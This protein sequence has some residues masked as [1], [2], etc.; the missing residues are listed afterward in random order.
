MHHLRRLCLTVAVAAASC[1]V[2]A[3]AQALPGR[4]RVKLQ[5]EVAQ[6]VDALPGARLQSLSKD[7]GMTGVAPLDATLQQV[8]AVKMRRV[9]PCSKERE[10]EHQK[11]GLDQWYEITFDESV[12]PLEAKRL[13]QSTAGVEKAST[14]R[15]MVLHETGRPRIVDPKAVAPKASTAMPF[16]DPKL[17]QQWHYYNDGSMAGAVAG[18]DINL[19]KAWD[20]CTGSK[21][22]VV[23]IIDGG[24]DYT[25]EDLADAMWINEAE[26]NGT[27]GVDDDG[28]GYIDDIYGYNFCTNSGTIYPHYHGTH[29]AGTI[30]AVNNNGKGVCG[31]AGG[32]GVNPGVRLM[33]CQVFDSRSGTDE[34]D[35]AAALVYAADKGAT[36]ASCSW[37][38]GT[39][40]Y[41]EED[42]LE[43]VRYFTRSA[44]SN[45]M[46]GGLCIFS[47]GNDG[48][49]GK[50]YPGAMDEVVAVASMTYDLLP[51]SYSNYGDW[52]D[53]TAPG[54]NTDYDEAQAVLS[55]YPGNQYAFL[56]GTS[57]ATPHVS[58][59]AALVLS[60]YG[61]STLINES[62]RQQ[63][64]TSVND[65]Y[66]R[67]PSYEGKF[68]S[69]YIDAYKALQWSDG[70]APAA[71]SDLEVLPA[72]DYA[73][74]TWTIP[75]SSDNQVYSHIIYYNTQPFTEETL[76]DCNSVV[77]DTKFLSSGDTYTYEVTDLSPLTTYY[78]AIRAVDRWSNASAL[79]PLVSATTNAGPKMS[80]NRTSM[81][82]STSDGSKWNT[83]RFVISNLDEGLLKWS[84]KTRTTSSSILAYSTAQGLMTTPY[85]G[86]LGLQPKAI[87]S[88]PVE[89]IEDFTQEDYPKSLTYEQSLYAFLGDTDSSKPNSMAQLFTISSDDFPEGFNLTHVY[90]EGYYGKT[91]VIE[92]YRNAGT[93]SSSTLLETY[94]TT[95]TAAYYYDHQLPETLFFEP[96]E[97]FY[98][99]V[100][101]TEWDSRSYPLGMALGDGS[102]TAAQTYISNDLGQTWTLLSQALVGSNYEEYAS[103]ATWAITVK[104]KFPDWSQILSIDPAEGQLRGG[105][106][107]TQTVAVTAN[108]TK[109]PN[110][111][112]RTKILFDT[113]ETEENT[114]AVNAAI[115]VEG[116][117]PD[118]TYN[119]II[120][121]GNVL[122]G[123]S[124]TISIELVNKGYGAFAGGKT[125]A[126]LYGDNIQSTSEHFHGPE[127]LQS[128]IPSRSTVTVDLTYAPT[129]A[130]SHNGQIKLIDKDGYTVTLNV[131]G[132]ATDPAKLV[133]NPSTVNV[134]ELNATTMEGHDVTFEIENQGNYPLQYVMT[135]FSDEE[136]DEVATSS[137]HRFGYNWIS[138]LYGSDAVTYEGA[139][140]L[141]D[142][143]D[144]STE[145]GD[146]TY[147]SS[148]VEIGF[149]FPFYGKNYTQCHITSWGS[150]TFD[151]YTG[152]LMYFPVGE[153]TTSYLSGLGVISAYGFECQMAPTS[154]VLYARQDGKFVVSYKDVLVSVYGNEYTP[155]SFHIAL[156]PSGD[157]DV[158]FDDYDPSTVFEKGHNLWV[159]IVDPDMADPLT[160][161][162][163]GH[164]VDAYWYDDT[165]E[166][167]NRWRYISTGSQFHFAA[168]KPDMIRAISPS[169]GIVPP[170]ES[171]T[172]TATVGATD[173]MY[174]GDTYTYLVIQSND[175]V[176]PT[177]LVTFEGTVTGDLQ[178]MLT[179]DQEVDFGQ[180]FRTST[181]QKALT[182]K[183]SGRSAMTLQSAAIAAGRFSHDFTEAVT[184]EPGQSKDIVLT[185]P[186]TV[187]GAVTDQLS[188][189][190]SAGNATVSLKGEV[191]G[192][193]EAGLS[194]ESL[195]VT[196]PS[197]S[198]EVYP[199]TV[200]NRGNETLSYSIVPGNHLSFTPDY[201]E[202][203]ETSYSY[204]SSIDDASALRDWV[205]IETTGL[206][207]QM[208]YTHFLLHDIVPVE[209]PFEFPYYGGKYS[210][211]YIV[212]SGF[213]TFNQYDDTAGEF[214]EPPEEFPTG[215]LYTNLLAPYWGN[216]TMDVTSTSGIFYYVTDD[217]AVV[218]F[219]EYGNSMNI[220]IDFQVIL[221][222]DGTFT[223]NYK[224][225]YDNATLFGTFGLAGIIGPTGQ[226]GI[227]LPD[228]MI[229]L[230]SSVNFNPVVTSSLA[231][232]ES[233]VADITVLGDD[234]AG[235]YSTAIKVNTN[236]PTTPE[237]PIPVALTIT[238]EPRAVF[239][240]DITVEQVAEY[241]SSDTSDDLIGYYGAMWY[242]PLQVA[243]EGTKAFTVKR[244]TMTCPQYEG[245]NMFSLYYYGTYID[246]W[247]EQE[248]T[249]WSVYT[250]GSIE[251]G[252]SPLRLA[253]PLTFNDYS[254]VAWATPGTYDIALTFSLSGIDG[255]TEKTVN[256]KIIIT[257][258]PTIAVD[259][260]EIRVKATTDTYVGTTPFTISN[261]QG[262]YKLS[263]AVVVDPT[264]EGQA[265]EAATAIQSSKQD[266]TLTDIA[267]EMIPA[268]LERRLAPKDVIDYGDDDLIY[269]VPTEGSLEYRRAIY[270]PALSTST[271]MWNYGTTTTYGT[272]KSATRYVGPEGGF[273]ISHIYSSIHPYNLDN[274]DILVEIY[275]CDP[276]TGD[277][278]LGQG[279]FHIGE[280]TTD[281]Y[282]N[283]MFLV[284]LDTPVYISEGQ[285]FY[286]VITY[287]QGQEYPAGLIKKEEGYISGRYL[288]YYDD[289]GWFDVAAVF[290]DSYG[291]LGYVAT[292]LETHEGDSW[293]KLLTPDG[294]PVSS[295]SGE[296]TKGNSQEIKVQLSAATAPKETDNKAMLVITSNDPKKSVINLPVYLDKNSRPT[297]K[298]SLANVSV[299]EG[300]EATVTC[301]IADADGDNFTLSL[302]DN[303]SAAKIVAVNSADA[304]VPA[305][306]IAEDGLSAT[307]EGASTAGVTATVTIAPDY[308]TA[309]SYTFS[310]IATDAG[311]H[312]GSA[313]VGY[314]VNHVNRAPVALD[315]EA[316][317]VEVGQSSAPI[318]LYTWFNDPDG[319][320]LT[321]EINY[322][323]NQYVTHYLSGSKVIFYGEKKG[324]TRTRVTATDP[325][326]ESATVQV[327]ITTEASGITTISSID[328][329]QAWPNPVDNTLNL[330][331]GETA[332]EATVEIYSQ[333]GQMT[334]NRD[335][336]FAAA[337]P[338][339]L[340]LGWL[341]AG[342]YLLRVTTTDGRV[343][344]Q[345]LLKQ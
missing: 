152:G 298:T 339:T 256:V 334:V 80:I 166:E 69:G 149:E 21:D 48:V 325:Y 145:F 58:G 28:D 121:F 119:K 75:A 244:I 18:A 213:V 113:N 123:Q 265:V 139:P 40:G 191:I 46:T 238:G 172:V 313:N 159:G 209:L 86:H 184:I 66:T 61:S 333:S 310:M 253:I 222:K 174:A 235:S 182:V 50:Y 31:V 320:E 157:I 128:G 284:A 103:Q 260:D 19:F 297:V 117:K 288:G 211:M 332:A 303:G 247:T 120:Q 154:K 228:R 240:D 32:D 3:Q 326:G 168:P 242:V 224:K 106:V 233:R 232:G 294:E 296:V 45:N 144:V 115:V 164:T 118:V 133:A 279:T 140:A 44:R 176:N 53:I 12:N 90:L 202:G 212:D 125:S 245:S 98:V 185:L 186:T 201:E 293:V 336:R 162:S 114:L 214:P 324:V 196:L 193:P 148:P 27:P 89:R 56:D 169:S 257:P 91:P 71:V 49:E 194:Y 84:A 250:S 210:K 330:L 150:I 237:I 208:S 216:H 74:L 101:F 47:T 343:A 299:D 192:C 277:D 290:N 316:F 220:G 30:G 142:A 341:P 158:A 180:V 130:G 335:I 229:E 116:Q 65:F 177:T 97:S 38:W 112:Y 305:I 197:G 41:Y 132:A 259:R 301:A 82:I 68:G 314:T 226:E 54:G 302:V 4:V 94:Q 122:V 102:T 331:L 308:G 6:Q 57:M 151:S 124:K 55:T 311:N 204:V 342:T 109:I 78:F 33:S 315:V 195:S 287:P 266:M 249:G 285:T 295:L 286:V 92:I 183:N 110:G 63:L 199:L 338:A 322:V 344:T 163:S 129:S 248:A 10:A 77:V 312:E 271:V 200:T 188:I 190:T 207:T 25:H 81:T 239:P 272:Y 267:M 234:L 198:S 283:Q 205:D 318:D 289:Y 96:G 304:T 88:T 23:A 95:S 221:R 79:S 147:F 15:K 175:I 76:A 107:E 156:S 136:L 135:K 43:A 203:A 236:V 278:V 11:Y 72:Q 87:S 263:Y 100:H 134:G 319:D 309:G 42:V 218:S 178:P 8:K 262:E 59:V 29:V 171:V 223:F 13:L 274:T 261:A 189:T 280:V 231:P 108:G 137:T 217:Q 127:Y 22:V 252:K 345:L 161:T 111:T 64:L 225:A 85:S 337:T 146:Y 62:L 269:N 26:L 93:L 141:L 37:G 181:A 268:T 60:K 35:Y 187:E 282:V 292:C 328:G 246:S 173:E 300:Q 24:V 9:F 2:C 7:G 329:F 230:E 105:N 99:V 227:R 251:V 131:Q 307:I 83:A 323:L 206:G 327:S 276:Q 52:V 275:N 16:N 167:G 34:G 264:G 258:Q 254:S 5:R 273:N 14:K 165:S 70:S 281:L 51:A 306:S 321:F 126:G 255:L 340:D 153:T 143:T 138:N 17:S 219:I 67:N 36:I 270:W 160:V 179:V 317:S 73:Q 39:E 104:S 241:V 20:L 155:A 243:N 170:G 1:C 291:S 215:S